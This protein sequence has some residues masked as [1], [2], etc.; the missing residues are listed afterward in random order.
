MALRRSM[1]KVVI[2]GAGQMGRAVKKLLN[3]NEMEFLGFADNDSEKWTEGSGDCRENCLKGDRVFSVQDAVDMEP[4]VIIISVLG[5]ERARQLKEQIRI[6]RFYGD[7]IFLNELYKVFDIRSRCI[8]ELAERVAGVE[9]AV[10]ELGVYKGDT[11]VQLNELFP[12]RPLYLFDTFSGFDEGDVSVEAAGGFSGAKAGDFAD[13]SES[14]VLARMPY[15]EQCIIRKGHFPETA[16]GLAHAR[17]AFVSLDPDLYEPALAG[18]EFFYSRMSSGGVIVVHD[19][20]NTQFTGIKKAV[21]QFDEKLVAA[22]SEPMKL[23]P[24][25]DL[26]GSCVIIK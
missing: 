9:G 7:I 22:G 15:P 5:D 1:K 8:G 23:V 2:I 6:C 25:G 16:A 14:A 3:P 12:D 10:A 20:N 21:T 17:F 24:L 26:H 19:Y 18:L 4:D 13:T 11:A